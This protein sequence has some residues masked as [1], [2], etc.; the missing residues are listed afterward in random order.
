MASA[1]HRDPGCI[2]AHQV[3]KTH[4]QREH[5]RTDDE[6]ASELARPKSRRARSRHSSGSSAA[7]RRVRRA[8]FLAVC[9][10]SLGIALNTPPG[11]AAARPST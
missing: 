5:E 4:R 2:A 7:P 10:I 9:R 11:S 6:P 3:L 1:A 8:R